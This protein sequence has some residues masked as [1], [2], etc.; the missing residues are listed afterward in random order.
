MVAVSGSQKS[1][2][3][4]LWALA[5]A[6]A[7]IMPAAQAM[8]AD[9]INFLMETD[10]V[11]PA[12]QQAYEAGIQK[13]NQCLNQNGFPLARTA[14]AQENGTLFT[15]A[16]ISGPATWKSFDEVLA[17]EKACLPVKQ[18][19]VNPHLGSESRRFWSLT[20]EFSIHYQDLLTAVPP[21][22]ELKY[23][24]IKNGVK[25]SDDFTGSI[26][27][28]ATAANKSTW[29]GQLMTWSS[30]DGD[31]GEPDYVV[32]RH[33]QSMADFGDKQDLNYVQFVTMLQ[34]KLG[35]AKVAANLKAINDAIEDVY[36]DLYSYEAELSLKHG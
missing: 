8:D 26:S 13:Y 6:A 27:E 22:L 33:Y 12:Q 31:R 5:L 19:A 35:K 23:F 1:S 32:V 24:A 4:L 15:Y 36:F 25:P 14:W 16:Y 21:I 7:S 3:G 9:Q 30:M 34:Q 18:S 17:A 10:Q 28:F 29:K 20:P 11:S 2:I